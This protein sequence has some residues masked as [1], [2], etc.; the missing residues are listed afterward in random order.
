MGNLSPV[1]P[2]IFIGAGLGCSAHQQNRG[3]DVSNTFNPIATCRDLAKPFNTGH[4]QVVSNGITWNVALIQGRLQY[5]VH[6]AQ[7]LET[8]EYHLLKLGNDSAVQAVRSIS[9]TDLERLGSLPDVSRSGWL[10][11]VADWLFSRGVLGEQ[12]LSELILRLSK[13]ALESMLWLMSG[14][15]NWSL[16][17]STQGIHSQAENVLELSQVVDELEQRMQSWQMLRPL[18]TSPYQQP[19]CQNLTLLMQPVPNGMLSKDILSMLVKLM[20]GA[21]IR[22]L[23]IFLKQDDLRVA[24]LLY[25]YLAHRVLLLQSPPTPYNYLPP[26]PPRASG[27][28][29]SA[30]EIL[31]GTP[32]SPGSG[33][34]FSKQHKIVCIDDSP[35][36]LETIEHYLGAKNFEVIT[37][38]NPMESLTALFGMK[39][40]LI[41]MDVSMPGINGNRLCQI[42]RRSAIFKQIPII[43]VSGNTGMLDRAKAQAAGATDYLTKPFSREDLL[44]IVDT[45]LVTSPAR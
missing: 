5:A 14:T 36:M 16:S 12:Q 41:L 25:P 19:Y 21:S 17:E 22:R 33:S 42:L 39:P 34:H 38:E 20:Q 28:Q 43:M 15:Y 44:A 3:Q 23:S 2:N 29:A 26:I 32:T 8:L 24:Q 35:A 4:L 45:Y 30:S 27:A 11:K 1:T 40:D 31:A 10:S 18:I 9:Q 7:S 6:S 13:D 37:V